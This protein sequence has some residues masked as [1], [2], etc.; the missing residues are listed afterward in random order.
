MLT[1]SDIASLIFVELPCEDCDGTGEQQRLRKN[2]FNFFDP[3][4]DVIQECSTCVGT[5]LRQA[6]VCGLCGQEEDICF[7]TCRK[8]TCCAQHPANCECPNGVEL[9]QQAYGLPKAA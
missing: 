7:R 8:T 9:Y 5:G 3:Y 2:V 6:E 1:L 4:E